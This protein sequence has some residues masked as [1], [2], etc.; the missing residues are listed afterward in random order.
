MNHVVSLRIEV[1]VRV[2]NMADNPDKLSLV[3]GRDHPETD[4]SKP[5]EL[6]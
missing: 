1:E 5:G 3:G 2:A 4:R 6:L